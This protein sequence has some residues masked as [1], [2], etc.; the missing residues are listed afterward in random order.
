VV[1]V[2]SFRIGSVL[3]GVTDIGLIG[4]NDYGASWSNPLPLGGNLSGSL[5]SAWAN[6]AGVH[7]P[8]SPSRVSV[9]NSPCVCAGWSDIDAGAFNRRRTT[10]IDQIRMLACQKFRELSG[11]N[12]QPVEISTLQRAVQAVAPSDLHFVLDELTHTLDVEGDS[13]NGGGSFDQ[14]AEHGRILV[15]YAPDEFADLNHHGPIRAGEIGSPSTT[16]AV[17][18]KTPLGGPPGMTSSPAEF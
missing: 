13:Q 18:F 5:P 11:P 9:P 2:R 12:N 7:E 8:T 10:R 15:Y 4:F 6:K 16:G 1:S 3:N 14:R 17:P